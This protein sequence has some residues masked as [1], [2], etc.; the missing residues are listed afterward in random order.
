MKASIESLEFNLILK[1]LSDYARSHEGTCAAA[2]WKPY[3]DPEALEHELEATGNTATLLAAYEPKGVSSL[4]DISPAVK[5]CVT[6]G[7]VLDAQE[8]YD[9]GDYLKQAFSFIRWF[10]V[11]PEGYPHSMP[12][13]DLFIPESLRE[14]FRTILTYLDPPGAVSMDH[15]RLKPLIRD[16]ELHKRDRTQ[17]SQQ[18]LSIQPE[19]WQ[20]DS[21]TI[22]DSRIVLPLKSSRKSQIK[23]IVHGSSASGNTLFVEPEQLMESNNRVII[24]EQRIQQEIRRILSELTDLIRVH[25]EE[26]AI[27]RES[28]RRCDEL[29]LKARFTLV[30]RCE[31]P[32]ITETTLQLT[33]ARHPLLGREAVP[34]NIRIPEE[35]R[36]VVMTGPNAGGKTVTVK[37]IG[38]L[39]MMVQYGIP[40]PAGRESC[41]P[42][43]SSIHADIGDDQSIAESLSTFSGHMK[44]IAGVLTE[45][46]EHA[47]VILDELASGTDTFE[48]S[49]LARGI[50]EHCLKAGCL[51]LVTSHHMSLKQ[52][53]YTDIRVINA[54]MEFDDTRKEPTYR[55]LFG[56]PGNSYAIETAQRMGLPETVIRTAR[57]YLEEESDRT[58]HMVHRLEQQELDLHRKGQ[59][60]KEKEQELVERQREL[61]LLQLQLKQQEMLLRRKDYTTVRRFMDESR[62]ELEQLIREIR[63][64]EITEDKLRRSKEFQKKLEQQEQQLNREISSSRQEITRKRG[65]VFKEGMHV[66]AGSSKREGTLLRKGKKQGFWHVELGNMRIDIHESDLVPIEHDRKSLYSDQKTVEVRYEK[67]A[68]QPKFELDLRGEYLEEALKKLEE[69]I[70]RAVMHGITRFSIIH[71]K[72]EGILQQG[73]HEHLSHHPSIE[74]IRFA[75][76]E[77]GGFGKSIVELRK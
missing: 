68:S 28:V 58:A 77:E 56:T 44:K 37:T 38:L 23:G 35:K 32:R 30:H 29:Y 59:A 18:L 50:I 16:L 27:A 7:L 25:R 69:Q 2:S 48:G 36:A 60:S 14:I 10:T 21:P 4:P 66:L 45:I 71:G 41:I 5:R 61:D 19:Q 52:F 76:P 47:L 8:M 62:R 55:V 73:I 65:I 57:Q 63:E 72:G 3:T 64:G 74:Q 15:P 26:I 67:H 20:Q 43:F 13:V 54:S 33:E 12:R 22:R 1:E 75:P 51:T 34:I 9:V 17:L 39:S 40:I 53:A 31:V 6:P 49:A 46:D 24:Q 70:D 42:L 11:P